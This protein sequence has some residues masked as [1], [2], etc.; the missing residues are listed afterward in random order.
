[1]SI[2]TFSTSPVKKPK[3]H[4]DV[5]AVKEY[6]DKHRISFSKVIVDL[7]GKFKKEKLDV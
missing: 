5:V 1:M 7:L 4:A 6:C 2:H 3:E